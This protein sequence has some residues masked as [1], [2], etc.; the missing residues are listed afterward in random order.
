MGCG[1]ACNPPYIILSQKVDYMVWG[2]T[3][4]LTGAISPE[5]LEEGAQSTP[6][7][8]PLV[9]PKGSFSRIHFVNNT[10]NTRLSDMIL[11]C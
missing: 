1:G 9:W 11:F 4:V 2:I 8:A 3:W 7:K 10:Q 5:K 6:E